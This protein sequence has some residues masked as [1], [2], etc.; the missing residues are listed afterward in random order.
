MFSLV[1]VTSGLARD[2]SVDL[3][4]RQNPRRGPVR[5]GGS[6]SDFAGFAR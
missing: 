4:V 3:P 1:E 6:F 2:K 5:P